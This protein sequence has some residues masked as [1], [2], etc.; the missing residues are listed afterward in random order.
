LHP[1]LQWDPPKS[2]GHMSA[3]WGFGQLHS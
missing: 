2:G 3:F 1:S